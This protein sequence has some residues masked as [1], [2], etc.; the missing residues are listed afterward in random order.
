M[1]CG[2]SYF[3][4]TIKWTKEAQTILFVASHSTVSKLGACTSTG[5]LRKLSHSSRWLRKN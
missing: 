2:I 5:G 4:D 3:Q 1:K